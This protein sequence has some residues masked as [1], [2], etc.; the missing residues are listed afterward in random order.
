[1][2]KRI[3]GPEIERLIQLLARVPGLGPRSARR[4]ALHLIKKK[5]ALLVPLGGAMQE[6]AEKVRICSCC[7]NVD[8]SDPCTICTDERR[9]PTT[10]IVVE[11][12][13]DLWALERA[14]TMNVRYHVLGGRLSPLDGIGPDD[15]NI[16]GLVERVS[17][18][19]IKEVIL[20]V[21]ATVEG[22]TTA[23]YITDQ[24]SSF[25]VRVTRLAHGVPV[26]GELD[27]LDEGTLA[28]ALRA[29]TTL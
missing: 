26:G 9:D 28:A 14:G 11:D 10:L 29:R 3:A 18:G 17:T 2:S 4:A 12:V 13:S 16:K 15:L 19:E 1:M 21:N 23:H 5:E 20:A 24:L 25:D 22:Q 8:T 27:Y 7:G 6:A